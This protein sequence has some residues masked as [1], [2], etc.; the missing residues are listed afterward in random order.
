MVNY[1]V[2]GKKESDFRGFTTLNYSEKLIEG[3]HQEEVDSYHHCF[4]KLFKWLTGVIALRKQDIV[5][6]KAIYKRDTEFR[7]DKIKEKQTRAENRETFLLEAGEKF[8][9]DNAETIENC[10]KY[11]RLVE[12]R[13]KGEEIDEAGLELLG[14]DVPVMPEHNQ[15]EWE[16]KFDA[17]HPD[18]LIPEPVVCEMDNDWILSEQEVEAQIASYLEKKGQV[19]I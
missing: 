2:L 5:R 14:Q 10:H 11:Q 15:A 3:I 17:E 9:T 7:E 6:R 1:Q 4:G 19:S 8:A 18:I 12:A 16:E 13:D